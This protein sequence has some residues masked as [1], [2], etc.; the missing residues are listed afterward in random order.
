M[1]PSQRLT[2]AELLTHAYFDDYK[3]D[4]RAPPAVKTRKTR[5]SRIYVI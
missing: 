1:E 5:V 3:E 4:T 2:C